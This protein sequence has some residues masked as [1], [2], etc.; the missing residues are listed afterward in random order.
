MEAVRAWVALLDEDDYLFW[1]HG[2]H[3]WVTHLD[4]HWF[5]SISAF[6]SATALGRSNPVALVMD[7]VIPRGEETKW[8]SMLLLH[9]SCSQ[10]C[11]IMLSSELKEEEH[12]LWMNLGATDHL[13]KPISIDE[14]KATVLAVSEHIAARRTE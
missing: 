2:F 6:L 9:P 5:T 1:Q 10:A 7:G 11:M 12:Q 13:I 4:L 3:F 8:L 14:L